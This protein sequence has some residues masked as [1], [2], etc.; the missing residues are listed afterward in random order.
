M[1]LKNFRRTLHFERSRI[2]FIPSR[3]KF[4]VR[5]AGA[6]ANPRTPPFFC[7]RP[8]EPK[9]LFEMK[10]FLLSSSFSSNF[11]HAFGG[12]SNAAVLQL[13]E[14]FLN[15]ALKN[16][17]RTLHFERPEFILS[18]AEKNSWYEML[19]QKLTRAPLRSFAFAQKNQKAFSK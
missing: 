3:K 16:F 14:Y 4:L 1:A 18:R 15:L 13:I 2:Y 8:K 9:G 12:Y 5:N 7:I 10:A 6:K 19:A 11:S 17:H